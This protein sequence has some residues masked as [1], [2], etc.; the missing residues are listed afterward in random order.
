[1]VILP[2]SSR[3]AF[4]KS[5]RH[6]VISFVIVAALAIG[7]MAIISILSVMN[8]LQNS[9][10][11][12]MKTIE[13]F[14]LEVSNLL[15]STTKEEIVGT[16]NELEG[17]I[18]AYPYIETSVIV[19]N[20]EKGIS[21]TS[22]MRGVSPSLFNEKNPLSDRL[23]IIDMGETNS[24]NLIMGHSLYKAVS[25]GQQKEVDISYLGKGKAVSLTLKSLTVPI[26]RLFYSPLSEFDSS[27]FYIDI[28]KVTQDIGSEKIVYG[29]YVV[30]DRAKNIAS[31]KKEIQE[32]YPEA[33]I[34]SWQEIHAPFYSALYLEKL[35]MYVFLLCIF[36]IVAINIKNS[37]NRL[38]HAKERE[39]AILRA[40]GARKGRVSQIIITSSM[41]I[42]LS[43]VVIGIVLG[44]LVTHNI[45]SIFSFINVVYYAIVGRYNNFF[46]YPFNAFVSVSEIAII[47][48]FVII[49]SFLFTYFGTRR[50]LSLEPM[51]MLNHE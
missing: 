13:S 3:Y 25:L 39:L 16:L 2:I 14:H 24:F 9:L 11:Q 26:S 4:S 7:M 22:R 21:Q 49:V 45:D 48:S 30:D 23:A 19:Q 31:L 28:D 15:Q 42:T 29:L 47:S 46:S 27:T 1:M 44:L 8:S 40:L 41:I 6:R 43:G 10:I 51:E 5:N 17:V 35:L 33:T 36:F 38:I 37:T 32:I 18:G 12:E 50:L 34:S 20:K